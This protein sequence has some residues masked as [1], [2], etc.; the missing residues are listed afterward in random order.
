[1]R[2]CVVG[3]DVV[4]AAPIVWNGRPIVPSLVST[5][6]AP[7]TKR[8]TALVTQGRLSFGSLVRSQPGGAVSGAS[9]RPSL[10]PSSC[11]FPLGPSF[12]AI[13]SEPPSTCDAGAAH[14]PLNSQRSSELDPHAAT[15]EAL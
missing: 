14:V 10:S 4:I 2:L 9:T 11:S 3:V 5:P 1:M 8:P 6:F 15:S 7:S 13:T 12:T